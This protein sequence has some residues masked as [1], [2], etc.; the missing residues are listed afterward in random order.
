MNLNSFCRLFV[1]PP[2]MASFS[3]GDKPLQEG[4]SVSVQCSVTS[5][6]LP[7]SIFWFYNSLP[8]EN[9]EFI[10]ISRLGKRVSALTI[11]SVSHSFVGNYT[12]LGRNVAGEVME[13]AALVVNGWSIRFL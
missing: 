7:I 11:D 13:T 8:V 1:V 5:G 2:K 4:D 12:C 3:F 6:D 10:T 9:S